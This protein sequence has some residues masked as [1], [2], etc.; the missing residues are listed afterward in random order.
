M[1]A[2]IYIYV[3]GYTI[4][5]SCLGLQYHAFRKGEK[6]YVHLPKAHRLPT[7]TLV[8]QFLDATCFPVSSGEAR[9]AEP[10]KVR[11]GSCEVWV[12]PRST[13]DDGIPMHTYVYV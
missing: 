10:R 9:L 8:E 3:N 2:R 4:A 13:H 1:C 5:K 12:D 7:S 11:G 6:A